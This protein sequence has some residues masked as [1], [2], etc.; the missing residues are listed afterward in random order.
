MKEKTNLQKCCD[1]LLQVERIKEQTKNK[2]LISMLNNIFYNISKLLYIY[3]YDIDTLEIE[4]QQQLLDKITK[5][6]IKRK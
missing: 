4:R 6:F 5:R 3:K 1:I 2:Y